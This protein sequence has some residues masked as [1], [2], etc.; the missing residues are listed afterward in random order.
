MSEQVLKEIFPSFHKHSFHSGIILAYA[1]VVGAG[2]KRFGLSSPYSP[3]FANEM[4]PVTEYAAKKRG[5]LIVPEDSLPVTKLFR[6][7]VAKDKVVYMIAQNQD[8]LDEYL[9]VKKLKAESDAQGN[10]DDIEDLIAEKFGKL[11]SYKDDVIN[12]LIEKNSD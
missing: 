6:R 12:R 7:D 5:V 9:E 10:P 8:V 1:E 3:E 2:I 4:R 11:L